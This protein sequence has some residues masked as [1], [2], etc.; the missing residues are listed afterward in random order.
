MGVE[1][2]PLH[3]AALRSGRNDSGEGFC[4][5]VPVGMRASGWRAGGSGRVPWNMALLRFLVGKYTTREVRCQ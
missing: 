4:A 1:I 3:Y 5:G 2:P